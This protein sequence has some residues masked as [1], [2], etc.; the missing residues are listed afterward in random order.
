MCV[1]ETVFLADKFALLAVS[2]GVFGPGALQAQGLL[3]IRQF[4]IGLLETEIVK[5]NSNA[6]PFSVYLVLALIKA[7][8]SQATAPE[9]APIPTRL[10]RAWPR[11]FP[12]RSFRGPDIRPDDH[13][14]RNQ[15]D[16][17][18]RQILQL[19]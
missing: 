12:T 2:S 13:L 7:H 18:Y 15:H 5:R 14:Q 8:S 10:V 17:R 1:L 16:H 19:L 3:H 9:E 11:P 6:P 4:P